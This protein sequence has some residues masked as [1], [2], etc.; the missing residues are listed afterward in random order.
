ML[1]SEPYTPAVGF[2]HR[3]PQT[4]SSRLRQNLSYY[5][6]V[7]LTSPFTQSSELGFEVDTSLEGQGIS[8]SSA[9][10]QSFPSH[11]FDVQTSLIGF[12]NIPTIALPRDVQTYQGAQYKLSS[13]ALAL[14]SRVNQMNTDSSWLSAGPLTPRSATRFAP[15][16]HRE[17]SL[18]S[19]GSA[20][21]ASP[22][23]HT[24][25]QPHVA[26]ADSVFDGIHGLPSVD[27]FS[28]NYQVA[29]N[30]KSF[31]G[32]EAFYPNYPN[33]APAAATAHT[34]S[35]K[36]MSSSR[37]ENNNGRSLL[38]TPGFPHN[39]QQQ[40]SNRPRPISVAS[41]V[42]D[43]SPA[44]PV[45]EPDE[46]EMRRKN[47]ESAAPHRRSVTSLYLHSP[48]AAFNGI[49]KLDRTM[50]D[51]YSDELFN[52]NFTITSASPAQAHVSPTNE[53]FAQRLQ[54][55]NSQHLS[56]VPSPAST[57]S[58]G[59]PFRHGSPLA[60]APSHDFS[61]GTSAHMVFGSSQQLREQRK[62]A[63]DAQAMRQQLAQDSNS[64]TPQTIS[65]KDAVIHTPED[66]EADFPL[67]PKQEA[68]ASFN[69][70]HM[71]HV[72]QTTQSFNMPAD[73]RAFAYTAAQATAS[74]AT[75]QQYSFLPAVNQ[76][77]QQNQS[78][79]LHA[80]V[81]SRQNSA[82][83]A[84]SDSSQDGTGLQRPMG[85]TADGGTYTCTYHGCT[86]RFDTPALLQKHKREGHRNAHGITGSRRSES[87][88]LVAG[89]GTS[90]SDGASAGM[91]SALLNTQAGPHKCERINPSTNKPCNIMF[92]RPYDLTRHEDTIHNA[93]K[94]KVRCDLCSEEKTFSRA[95][96]LTRHYRVCHPHHEVPGKHRRRGGQQHV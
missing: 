78:S 73:A 12:D 83:S 79:H 29:T 77:Q 76:P 4:T 49:P 56:A 44:T 37:Q 91:T 23:S 51:I 87:V 38:P 9:A 96:A 53:V 48:N 92:S 19:L 30:T 32:Q 58:H 20:D 94:Q 74:L 2:P 8:Q 1:L 61:S 22:Y 86:L 85:M 35:N 26:V 16:H 62:A 34:Y 7:P 75:P 45:G 55:A 93:R 21:P 84:R 68:D 88:G 10:T 17:S 40:S 18:S 82:D 72:P 36:N 3:N 41:S 46:T 81:E 59:S 6:S 54:A 69:V 50:T 5:D 80:T 95:D 24:T 63:Q 43:D 89:T 64:G 60:P 57:A 47:G 13:D 15:Q 11:P 31:P 70:S 25:S 52:P 28:S 39:S 90:N 14:F 27:D 33:Y 65:P 71:D 67:F 42:A 66:G